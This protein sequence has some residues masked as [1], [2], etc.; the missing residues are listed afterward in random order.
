[1]YSVY[2]QIDEPTAV[3]C[4]VYCKLLPTQDCQLVVAANSFLRVY[5]LNRYAKPQA[6]SNNAEEP[7]TTEITTKLECVLSEAVFGNVMAMARLQLVGYPVDALVLGFRD[8]KVGVIGYDEMGH[9]F[10]TLTLHCFEDEILKEGCENISS[11]FLMSAD[12][13]SRCIALIVYGKHLGV[14]PFIPALA[15]GKWLSANTTRN[16]VFPDIIAARSYVIGLNAI[17]SR[18]FHVSDICFLHGF[19]EPTLLLLYEP[20]QTTVS[21]VVIRKDTFCIIAVSLNLKDQ[22]HAVIW[23][24]SHLPFDC[25]YMKPVPKPVGGIVIFAMNSVIYLN[26][27]VP[28]CGVL[29]N[30][31]GRGTSEYPFHFS[32]ELMITLDGSSADFITPSEKAKEVYPFVKG[33]LCRTFPDSL[34]V[35]L[36]SGD[37]FTATLLV[38]S[39]NMV[40]DLCFVRGDSSVI[41]SVLCKCSEGFLFVGSMLGNSVLLRYELTGSKAVQVRH[42]VLAEDNELLQPQIINDDVELYGETIVTSKT[43]ELTV[44]EYSFEVADSILNFGPIR[45]ITIGQGS[46]L[47]ASY[48]NAVDPVVDIVCATGHGKNGALLVLQRSVR[49][50]LLTST[51]IP[52]A[53][54]VWTVGCHL[55]SPLANSEKDTSF[56]GAQKFLLIS[57]S[58]STM[59]LEL[60]SEITELEA[61]GFIMD[62]LTVVAGSLLGGEYIVQVTPSKVV[63]I[64]ESLCVQQ[65]SLSSTYV[66]CDAAVTDPYV[67]LLTEYGR[68]LL[69]KLVVK[70]DKYR[71]SYSDPEA[72][73][74]V[75]A[76]AVSIY[77][78]VSGMFVPTSFY[79][80]EAVSDSEASATYEASVSSEQRPAFSDTSE[81]LI[82]PV[83]GGADMTV[84]DEDLL[85][86]GEKIESSISFGKE[87]T[88]AADNPA[89]KQRKTTAPQESNL[90]RMSKPVIKNVYPKYLSDPSTV[91]ATYWLFVCRANGMLEIFS[92]PN[93]SLCY[94]VRNFP[95]GFQSLFDTDPMHLSLNPQEDERTDV[96]VQEVLVV[97][98]GPNK[99]RPHIFAIINDHLLIY[100]AFPSLNGPVGDHLALRFKRIPNITVIKTHDSICNISKRLFYFDDVSGYAGIFVAGNYPYWAIMTTHGIL[101]IHPMHI[102]GQ[103][104]CFTPFHNPN[105]EYGFIYFNND[106]CMRICQ[107][108]SHFSYDSS[109]PAHKVNLKCTVH[110]VV[111]LLESHTYALASSV[112]EPCKTMVTLLGEEKHFEPFDNESPHFIYPQLDRYSVQLFSPETW[113]CIPNVEIQMDE[114]EHI[115]VF[116]EVQL[117]SESTMSG[118]ENYLA[119]GTMCNY[120]D[121]VLI[122]GRLF[123][124]DVIEV[125]PEPD[126][127]LTKNKFKI[128]YAKEQKGPVTSLCAANGYLLTGMGQKVYIWTFKDNEL[129]GISF[130][131]LQIYVFKMV[132]I[133]NMILVGDAFQSVSL[134]RYQEQFKAL[135]LASRDHH[136]LEVMAIDFVIDNRHLSFLA[137]DT[138]GNLFV[139]MLQP[140]GKESNGGQHLVR[141]A[142]MHVGTNAICFVRLRSHVSELAKHKRAMMARRHCLYIGGGD[143]SL[144]SFLPLSEKVYRRLLL[145]QSMMDTVVPHVAGLNPKS[146]RLVR[147]R[148]KPLYNAQKNI[149]NGNLL[150][151]YLST[152]VHVRKEVADCIGTT[153]QQ[154][155]DDLAELQRLTTHF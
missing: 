64:H 3:N 70:Q 104:K 36:R 40:K 30:E 75:P 76:V 54:R 113:T 12:P 9:C 122:R 63:L 77:K 147:D 18:L 137:S 110:F 49:P 17:D 33:S 59:V 141:R 80:S 85:L 79:S 55:T 5:R 57:K 150:F 48:V 22:T 154:L 142:D 98:L 155:F 89:K 126:Q 72:Y 119:F 116:T 95:S 145:L 107:L 111:Y 50:Q 34:V 134:L 123:I 74:T 73:Q 81:P 140:E 58:E 131:D 135:S 92:L 132:S 52:S 42:E 38:D 47:S 87:P 118:F 97:G 69:L 114:F 71:L 10:K 101:R 28:P 83:K 103:V 115:T 24:V 109:C 86:Y 20:I 99:A 133:R 43:E 105:C 44:N 53:W 84:D 121:E 25:L 148:R 120:G 151:A 23:A 16:T 46:D 90:L 112:K 100:E 60:T 67:V 13:E 93:Y 2:R 14:I 65:I 146:C 7:P 128:L 102:D 15:P 144:N 35:A 91:V 82:F 62:E 11:Q 139:Y 143:G 26:Q 4:A 32:T 66:I 37:L 8:A 124:V 39:L 129:V 19:H 51:L 108:P 29:L 61:S 27:S 68:I 96:S 88:D 117:K 21:R 130:L 136:S 45:D 1:M 153:Y 41:P 94:V 149:L 138:N 152:D 56:Q 6:C 125:V 127:P 106:S 31:N 78:D